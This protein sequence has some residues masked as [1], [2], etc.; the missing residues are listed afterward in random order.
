VLDDLT[1]FLA[2][3]ALWLAV[4]SVLSLVVASLLATWFVAWLPADYFL[5]ETR[6]R[7]DG[8][9]WLI[10]LI[11]IV[12]K[13]LLGGLLLLAGITMLFTPGQG[14]LTLLAGVLLTDFPGKYALERRLAQQDR[15]MKLLNWWRA[16]R[17]QPPFK[18]P[19]P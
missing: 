2:D 7:P 17:R 5:H 1:A 9:H 11:L 19:P 12:A 15:V 18:K 3:Y 6:S 16:R 10:R 4:F 8:E 13:N 14:L